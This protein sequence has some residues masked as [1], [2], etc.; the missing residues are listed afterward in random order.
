MFQRATGTRAAFK[1]AMVTVMALAGSIN[2]A[3]VAKV[4]A[5]VVVMGAEVVYPQRES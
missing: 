1:N 5:K 3:V 4:V 2:A